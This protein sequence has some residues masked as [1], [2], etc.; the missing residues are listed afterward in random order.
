MRNGS[1]IPSSVFVPAAVRDGLVYVGDTEGRFVCLDATSGEVKWSLST[2]AE[3]NAGANFYQDTVLIGSQ[4]GALYAP[5]CED[6]R[7]SLEILN[8]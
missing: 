2:D 5:E 6:W 4:N 7:T 8:R 1:F 3:I